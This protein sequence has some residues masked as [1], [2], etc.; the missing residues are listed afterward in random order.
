M[1][2]RPPS[3]LFLLAVL[4]LT[5]CPQG[6][7]TLPG[8]TS[9]GS[10]SSTDAP[11][12]T[13]TPGA[14]GDAVCDAGEPESCPEDC[15]SCGDG[16]V[17]G[18]EQ[19]DDGPDNDD[20]YSAE[21]H[22]NASCDGFAP[23]CGDDVCRAGDEDP[24][25]CPMD[26]VAPVCGN[27]V[28]EAGEQCDAGVKGNP[29]HSADCDD[30]CTKPMC[31]DGNVN[32]MTDEQCDDGNIADTDACLNSCEP[33]ACGDGVVHEGVEACDDGN[34]VE[35]DACDADCAVI[36][37]RRVFV[38]SMFFQADLGGVAGADN[39]C[40]MLG[41]SMNY[42]AWLS[43]TNVGP[44]HRF[45]TTFKGIYNLTD[46]EIVAH[47]WADLVDGELAHR[48]DQTET[49]ATVPMKPVWSNTT[50]AGEP[51]GSLHCVNWTGA[52]LDMDGSVGRS[53]AINDQWTEAE[54]IACVADAH[55]YC[56]EDP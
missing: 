37:H 17:D 49:G 30:D 35:T 36:E 4:P 29:T 38:T 9:T 56:F 54:D 41:G 46:G 28:T 15:V 18:G 43:N 39:T 14:C 48:I 6:G 10:E 50:P 40:R 33:A 21:K 44:V 24:A 53:D 3:A 55:L 19:C 32:P 11:T 26:C 45:D 22:C 27:G 12:G 13:T 23:H 51:L 47:G 8:T 5:A 16:L 1:P 20:G 31:G 34:D 7:F 52:L 42:K 25:K 2:L